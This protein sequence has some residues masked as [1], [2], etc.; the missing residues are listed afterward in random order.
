MAGKVRGVAQAKANLDAIIADVQGRKVVRAIQSAMLIGST[1]AALYTPIDT[2][3]LLNSQFRELN[4]N[5]TRVTGRVGYS[6]N[7]A[8]Y[9]HDP[10]VQ[11][12][13]RRV[14]ARKEFLTKGFEDSREQIDA[15]IRQELQL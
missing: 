15:T 11:Q 13:F 6:A 8:V 5:G 4:A 9:V 10:A 12:T 2:S 7:Y 1:Q 3:T 14:T